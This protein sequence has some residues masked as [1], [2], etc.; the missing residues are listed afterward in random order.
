[1][2]GAVRETRPSRRVRRG[3][4]LFFSVVMR[5]PC[6]DP[7]P[8]EAVRDLLG[9]LRALYAADKARG[10]GERHLMAV[11]DI[12]RELRRSVDL[13]LEYEP[14][15]LGHAAAWDRAERA[16]H[17]LADLVDVTT[18]VEPVLRAAGERVRQG[19]SSHDPRE[20][21]RR[22]RRERS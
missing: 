1:V 12:A 16:T 5:A 3:T 17:R 22:A 15:T 19:G 6:L 14:G 11:G 20:A 7:F 2:A 8:F 9:I 13:A 4:S 21:S 18:P 10:A